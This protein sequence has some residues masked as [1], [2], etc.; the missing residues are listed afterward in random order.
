MTPC[1]LA[2]R[3]ATFFAAANRLGILAAALHGV[4]RL[5]SATA[6][7]PIQCRKGHAGDNDPAHGLKAIG[8]PRWTHRYFVAQAT[9]RSTRRRRLEGDPQRLGATRAVCVTCERW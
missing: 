9:I 5:G 8:R 6:K 2:P 7:H 3:S 1:H 4:L